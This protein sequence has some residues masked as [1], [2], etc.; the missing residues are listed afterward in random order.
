MTQETRP[1]LADLEAAR[2]LIAQEYGDEYG[3]EFDRLLTHHDQELVARTLREPT[4]A[5]IIGATLHASRTTTD[6]HEYTRAAFRWI[7]Q[8]RLGG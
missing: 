8:E 3:D 6:S 4:R 2:M 5:E 7:A 1:L